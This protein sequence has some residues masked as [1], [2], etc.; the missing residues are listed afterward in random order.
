MGLSN[1]DSDSEQAD[2]LTPFQTAIADHLAE[3]VGSL[4][5]DRASALAEFL[6]GQVQHEK[7]SSKEGCQEGRN[8]WRSDIKGAS[9]GD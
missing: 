3:V 4:K 6:K 9:S 7:E 1:R 5:P 8:G 2:S